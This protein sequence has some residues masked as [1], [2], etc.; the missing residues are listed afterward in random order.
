MLPPL[1]LKRL[2]QLKVLPVQGNLRLARGCSEPWKDGEKKGACKVGKA[3]E[4]C[5]SQRSIPNAHFSELSI[6]STIDGGMS[7]SEDK[8]EAGEGVEETDLLIYVTAVGDDVCSRS[9]FVMTYSGLCRRDQQDRPIAGYINFCPNRSV[10]MMP[11]LISTAMR[12]LTWGYG[13]S[14]IEK[15]KWGSREEYDDVMH[16]AHELTHILGFSRSALL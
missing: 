2:L 6:W 4:S 12:V 11:R 7:F 8:M 15:S 14:R 13:G 16:V 10:N 9:D 3:T 1:T 5:G